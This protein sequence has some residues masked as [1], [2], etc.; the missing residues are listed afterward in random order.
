MLLFAFLD[1][2]NLTEPDFN[3]KTLHLNKFKN[4]FGLLSEIALFKNLTDHLL[5][6]NIYSG[7]T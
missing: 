4:D 6:L 2:Y 5:L 3:P 7:I 1:G